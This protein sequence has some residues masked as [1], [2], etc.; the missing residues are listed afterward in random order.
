MTIFTFSEQNVLH[1][2]R[3]KINYIKPGLFYAKKEQEYADESQGSIRTG[4]APSININ[5]D[6]FLDPNHTHFILV[7]D[8]SEGLFG[9]EI[10]FRAKFENELRKGKSLKYY[11]NKRTQR[12]PTS[13]LEFQEKKEIVPMILIVVNGGPNTLLTVV[14]SLEENIPILVLAVSLTIFRNSTLLGKLEQNSF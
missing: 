2:Y 5:S 13:N 11:E 6:I 10:K 12:F 1:F 9:K 14:E 3:F 4:R 7:D 8:G